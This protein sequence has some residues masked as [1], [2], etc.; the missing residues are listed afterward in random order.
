MLVRVSAIS[1]FRRVAPLVLKRRAAAFGGAGAKATRIA[2]ASLIVNLRH[3][4][5]A[6]ARRA[7]QPTTRN[8]AS[9]K[10]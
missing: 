8:D 2:E 10:D 7:S 3:V 5:A 4:R 6:P 1:H 9:S